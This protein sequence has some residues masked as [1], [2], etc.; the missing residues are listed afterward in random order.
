MQITVH[1]MVAAQRAILELRPA[2]RHA[3]LLKMLS[4]FDPMVKMVTPPGADP[5]TMFGLMR[6]DGPEDAYRE[7]LALLEKA[8]AEQT[9]SEALDRAAAAVEATGYQAPVPAIQFGLFLL[10]TN[11]IMM[12]LSQGYTGFGGTPG[13]ITVNLWPDER[14]LPKLGACVAHEFNHQ[15]R[16]TVVPWRMDIS[17]GEYTV[18]EGLAESF[19]AELYGPASV[20]P[21][22]SEMQPEALEQ[23]RRVVGEVLDLRGF[24]E[25]RPY[26]FGDEVMAAFGGGA[27]VG[28][29]AYAGYATGFHLV[30]AYLR[31][32]GKTAAEATLVDTAEI[33]SVGNYF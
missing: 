27:P 21:W 8:G 2:E 14:N 24:N 4:P 32:T 6:P 26:I 33:L 23:A 29:P 20:G 25:V 7:A 28:V 16:N 12:K 30:Q 31:R 22:V 13:Y 19:A 18:M 15:I 1:P 5:I 17:V 3:A 9:C 10:D 11:P